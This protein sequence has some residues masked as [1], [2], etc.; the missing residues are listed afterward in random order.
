MKKL[1]T[2]HSIYLLFLVCWVSYFSA[3]LGRLNF[4][5]C[6][7]AINE[8]TSLSRVELGRVSGAF[9]ICYGGAQLFSG[10]LADRL[11][12]RLLVAVGLLGGAAVNAGMAL[13]STAGQMVLLWALNG[14]L[15]SLIWT[16]MI[17][18]V[19]DLTQ[20]AQCARTCLNLSTTTPAGTLG[21]YLMCVL[22]VASPAGWRLSFWL[23]SAAMAAGGAVWIFGMRALERISERSGIPA[24]A[25]RDEGGAP[26]KAAGVWRV[27][28]CLV[29][30][31]LAAILHGLLR[32]GII[33]WAPSYLQESFGFPAATSIALTMI[34]PPVNLGGVY[35]FNWLKNR[36]RW[37]E[38]ATA[39]AAFAIC[40]AGLALWTAV[41]RG[42]V[43]VTV[44]MLVVSTTCMTGA[45]TMLLSLLPLRF[46]ALGMMAT[47]TGLLNASAYVGSA[48]AS[49]GF[50]A[51]SE[52]WGWM[53]VLVAWCIASAAGTALCLLSRRAG[54]AGRPSAGSRAHENCKGA[55]L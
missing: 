25:A 2:H 39:A 6:I 27:L 44:V 46:H 48:L 53:A 10:L 15:Q 24:V 13:S 26:E 22:C 41:G 49:T 47:V 35:A 16:P 1:Y 55:S 5:A 31:I 29:P 18:A 32:D 14:L 11:R 20:D 3:Y 37:S 42:S 34:V 36:M 12:P 38:T 21:A 19:A 40:G 33:T 51:L 52:R 17:K 54:C 43:P 8:T 23:G 4:T 45:S 9:I 7:A 30:V 28:V 50:G